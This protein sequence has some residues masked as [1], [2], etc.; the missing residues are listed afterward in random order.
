[1]SIWLAPLHGV[2][3]RVF[4]AA[5]FRHFSGIDA[6]LAPFIL[7]V[8]VTRMKDSHFKDLVPFGD[9]GAASSVPLVPQ[10]LGNNAEDFVSTAKVLADLGYAEVNWNLGC[11]YP[12]VAKKGRGSGLIP[13]PEKIQSFLDIAC[14][15]DF[16]KVS[17]KLRLGRNDREEIFSLLPALDRY[18]LERVILH[19]RIGVQMY[20]GSVDLDAFARALASSPRGLMY[21]GDIVDAVSFAKIRDR[22]PSVQD[23]MIG[24]GAL[25]DPFLPATL[26]SSIAGTAVPAADPCSAVRLATLRAFHDDLYEG[27]RS[28]LCGPA[29]VLDK[30]KEVWSYL[31][32]GLK[33]RRSAIEGISR[34]KTLDAYDAAVGKVFRE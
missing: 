28:V 16:I 6:V 31:G 2:T 15:Q 24:R 7:S 10:I 18:P 33:D 13:Y 5:Y 17:V 25:Y 21:N 12:M 14:A 34:A 19:P 30:M 1:M 8:P 29:H 11:P 23:W 22:F 9:A 4:R 27:Y 3:N 32:H 20:R 26:Q